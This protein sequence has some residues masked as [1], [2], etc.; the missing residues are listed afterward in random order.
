MPTISSSD[1]VL[2]TGANGYIALWIIKLLL[3]RGNSVR[4]A[5]R[6]ESKG[7]HLLELFKSYG[8][9][10]EL[11]IV[12]DMTKDGAWDE[13]IQGV[14]AVEHT[15]TPIS[16]ENQ[17]PNPADFVEPAVAG[18]VRILESA[19]K[20]KSDI[21]RVV[22]T[23]SLAA[24]ASMADPPRTYTEEDWNETSLKLVEEKGSEAGWLEIYSAS[25]TR[26]E[27]AAWDFYKKHKDDVAWDLTVIL[28]PMVFGP[29][30]GEA[31]S[32]QSI[33]GS[34][35]MFW[36]NV[37]SE[38]PKAKEQLGSPTV[39]VDVRDL[40]E[41][42]ILALEK[43]KAGGERIFVSAGQGVWQDFVD[44]AYK[45]NPPGRKLSPGFPELSREPLI[46]LSS[47]KAAEILGVKTRSVEEVVKDSLEDFAKR[48]F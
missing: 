17:K 33:N 14:Q 26:A 37:V 9:K 10:I 40:A 6:S 47:T 11:A 16:L 32:P 38:A 43:E 20:Y 28:P 30:L 2:V 8:N 42:H 3:E 4:A 19:L 1:K 45:L 31:S 36:N 34:V 18:T 41:G 13:A 29:T 24:V 21:K 44:V 22:I 15:A 27:K 39:W 25:K 23:S 48:G 5:V 35:Q 12:P 7:R 46:K